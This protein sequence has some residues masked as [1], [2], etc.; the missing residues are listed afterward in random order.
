MNSQLQLMLQQAIQ[1]FQDGNFDSA[2]LILK[3]VLHVDTKNL[4]A[5]HILGLIKASQTN[6]KEAADLLGRAARISPNDA[7]IQYNLAKALTDSGNNKDA[8]VHHKKA[9][10]LAPNNPEAW[11][12]YGKTASNLARHEEALVCYGNALNL[13]PDYVEAAL[14]KGATLK[15]LKRYEEAII[16][17]EQALKLNPNLAEGWANKGVALKELKRFDEAITHY[18]KALSLMPNY[19]EGWSNKGNVLHELKRFDEAITHYDQALSLMPNYHEAWTNKGVTL[20][21]LRRF[22]EAI[23]HYDQALSLM[24]NY[25]EAWTNKGV[26]LHALRRF[27]EAITH[28]DQALS[29]MPNYHEAWINKGNALHELRRFD[30]AITHYDQALS[31]IPSDHD[32]AWNKSLSLLLQGDFAKGLPLYES[33]W[34]SE[35]VSEGAGKRFFDKPTWLGVESLEGKTIFLYGEQGLGD[36]IQFCRYAPL[37]ANLGAKVLLEVP[38]TL[39]SL[40]GNLKGIHLVNP[41][42]ELPP[43]DYQCPL[44]SLPF[45]FGTNINN[46]PDVSPY[47]TANLD[48]VA[49][50]RSRLGIS[51]KVRIGI[52]WSSTSSFKEDAK[53]SLMLADFL[54]A[55]PTQGCEYIC[56]QK[57]LKDCDVETFK[58]Q[59][60]IQFFGDEIKDFGDTAALIECVDLVVSTC[61]SI[62][63]L[64]AALGKKTWILLSHVPDWRWLLDRPDSPWYP[65]VKLYRQPA[66]GDWDSVFAKVKTDLEGA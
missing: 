12:N 55:L 2:G 62:P 22:D 48:E 31:L 65:S 21:A 33:R 26:T 17:A 37:V 36:F 16:F 30:E 27:D 15:D 59:E 54:R 43:F 53:R 38:G 9:V 23:T 24:P 11:L 32:A 51:S 42:Q 1:A 19:A 29:L 58:A 63:H 44:L 10:S 52:A 61:T 40:M 18:D 34:S 45:A 46:I 7:S 35:K 8:L 14:N 25:H 47:L 41:G 28:Y 50:W 39:V 3:R 60:G 20:H 57:E 4:P 56:L 13:K 49:Q 64:S 5:L 6:Y 66:I